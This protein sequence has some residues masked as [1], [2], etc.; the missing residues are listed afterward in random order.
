MANGTDM[1]IPLD[2]KSNPTAAD[3]LYFSGRANFKILLK[4][5]LPLL[6]LVE[7][8]LDI[9]ISTFSKFVVRKR[10]DFVI[11]HFEKQSLLNWIAVRSII[12]ELTENI[13]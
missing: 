12:I 11:E 13:L 7:L 10:E 5:V 6:L 2:I 1:E 8:L 3:S 9:K 4:S